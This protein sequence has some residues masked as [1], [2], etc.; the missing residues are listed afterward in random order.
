[1][2]PVP[3]KVRIIAGPRNT[4]FD[5][6]ISD[7]VQQEGYGAERIYF[8][9]TSRPRADEVRRRMRRA[10]QHLG[11]AVKAFWKPCPGCDLG[12]PGCRYHVYY[13]AYDPDVARAYM[14]QQA[15]DARRKRK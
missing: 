3:S 6:H 11:V 8:G 10:G 15:A 13:S 7:L 14:A 2:A 9:I 1:M 4:S 12:G 5:G